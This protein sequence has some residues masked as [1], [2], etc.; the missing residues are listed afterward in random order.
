[1]TD[2][3]SEQLS[4]FIDGELP[5]TE[6]TLLL[7]RLKQDKVLQHQWQR[8][9]LI[10][11]A[12]RKNLPDYIY[13]DPVVDL[14]KHAPMPELKTVRRLPV[15]AACVAVL[16]VIG[17]LYYGPFFA[18]SPN[19][20]LAHNSSSQHS[21]QRPLLPPGHWD[22]A[23]PTV[24]SQLNH[25]LVDHSHY[26]SLPTAQTM[27]SAYSRAAGYDK[28]MPYSQLKNNGSRYYKKIRF[29]DQ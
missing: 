1:M 19:P 15:L 8:Y 23:K 5:K 20:G 9:H 11:D 2:K 12:M 13:T 3:T 4:A 6:Q 29:S 27:L 16:G 10:R 17:I 14:T 18:P 28:A 24:A 22:L 26:G 21:P 7:H 25:Y